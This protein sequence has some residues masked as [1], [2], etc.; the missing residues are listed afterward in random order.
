MPDVDANN[1]I[2]DPPPRTTPAWP[3]RFDPWL[4]RDR[5]LLDPDM[6]R[7]K[8]GITISIKPNESSIFTNGAKQA[9]YFL[10]ETLLP[11]HD[12]VLINLD[13]G[14]VTTQGEDWG[15]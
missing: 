11:R 8:V 5:L 6:P 14:S 1:Y 3:P 15:N 13:L 4:E 10:R 2:Y 7:L 12:V 9:A